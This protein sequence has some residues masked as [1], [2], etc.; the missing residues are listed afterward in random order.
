MII[1]T[2][3][4]A[5]IATSR[6]WDELVWAWDGWRNVSGDK[7]PFDYRRMV[8]LLNKAARMN[9]RYITNTILK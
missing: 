8:E 4:S 3:L 5:I 2:D 1:H 7:M 6:D 9:G